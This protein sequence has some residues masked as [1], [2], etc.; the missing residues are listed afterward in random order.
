[1]TPR[2]SDEDA[3]TTALGVQQ[4]TT[5]LGD[6]WRA[7]FGGRIDRGWMERAANSTDSTA[8]WEKT[9][10]FGVELLVSVDTTTYMA[11]IA[12]GMRKHCRTRQIA[13]RPTIMVLQANS[14]KP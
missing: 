6:K 7:C 3:K 13:S 4:E 8:E 14:R 2:A 12:H 1:M 10:H 5:K 11:M 9:A